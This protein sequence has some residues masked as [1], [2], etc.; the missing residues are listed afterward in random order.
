SSRLSKTPRLNGP[1]CRF[2]SRSRRWR[3]L[4]MCDAGRFLG[5]VIS[6]FE[7]SAEEPH[8]SIDVARQQQLAVL[9][10]EFAVNTDRGCPGNSGYLSRPFTA[11]L[12]ASNCA[13]EDDE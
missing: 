12:E 2:I 9:I 6:R 11:F 8:F 3:K 4:L 7:I 10:R 5:E 13:M 1:F